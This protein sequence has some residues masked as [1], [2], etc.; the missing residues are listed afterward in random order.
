MTEM[1]DKIDLRNARQKAKWNP[2]RW[3]A[4]QNG[5]QHY[6]TG[7]PCRRNHI[8]KRF[9][10]NAMCVE[11]DTF[12]KLDTNKAKNYELQAKYG[13]TF[14]TY[15]ELLKKQNFVCAICQKPE[16]KLVK[17]KIC[18]LAVDHCHET[19]R[20]RALLCYACNVGIGFFKHNPDLLRKAALYC[21]AT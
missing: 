9:T 15:T 2:Q 20:I 5:E 21:E 14:D 12:H 7:K 4:I 10:S 3:A 6:F 18:K 1:Y 17:K 13:I 11:C 16:S 19:G 8:S